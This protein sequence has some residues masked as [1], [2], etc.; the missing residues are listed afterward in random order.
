MKQ[1]FEDLTALRG[2]AAL[3]V[4]AFH[5]YTDLNYKHL[6][7]A[8]SLLNS[9]TFFVAKSYLFVDFFFILSG[10]ILYYSYGRLFLNEVSREQLVYFLGRRIG[11]MYPLH[12]FVLAWWLG[13]ECLRFLIHTNSDAF[14]PPNSVRNFILSIFLVQ[15][16]VP[17]GIG[18]NTPSWSISAEWLVNIVFPWLV[19]LTRRMHRPAAYAML[20][21][22]LLMVAWYCWFI[23]PVDQLSANQDHPILRC[24][25]E[26][27]AGLNIGR[28]AETTEARKPGK[29]HAWLVS[30]AASVLVIGLGLYSLHAAISDSLSVAAFA[31][32]I[33][34]IS[35]R[36][37]KLPILG[38]KVLAWLGERSYS[39]YL[40]HRMLCIIAAAT[41]ARIAQDRT[42]TG[43]E[44]LLWFGIVLSITV[45]VSIV[46]YRWIEV[47]ARYSIYLALDRASNARLE[48]KLAS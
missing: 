4:A 40:V 22:L 23:D 6:L 17:S 2:V 24:L 38:S 47:P 41:V 25:V 42:L 32:L 30:P 3:S 1:Q 43:S 36:T 44:T 46:T 27:S 19:L 21:L 8:D 18:W 35:L 15:A 5:F 39:I 14:S 26:F 7:A 29:F 11:R 12:I 45:V 10:F 16:W 13:F 31:A 34:I 28:I 20:L 33:L 37:S 48:R 9:G